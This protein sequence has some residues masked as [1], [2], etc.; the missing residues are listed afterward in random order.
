VVD[1]TKRD[2]T[3]EPMTAQ[4]GWLVVVAG[5]VFVLAWPISTRVP[6]SFAL[7]YLASHRR[8]SNLQMRDV[9]PQHF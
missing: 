5:H 1:G 3:R 4:D 8:Q 6:V 2:E 7:R 9:T